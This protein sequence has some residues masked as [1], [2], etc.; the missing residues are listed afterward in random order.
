MLVSLHC[1]GSLAPPAVPHSPHSC[2]P[3]PVSLPLQVF[4]EQKVMDVAGADATLVVQ[5][6]VEGTRA[7]VEAS[8]AP[9]EPVHASNGAA[10]EAA[11][12]PVRGRKPVG[13]AGAAAA[14]KKEREA[15]EAKE[16]K[17]KEEP[18]KKPGFDHVVVGVAV[19]EKFPD[20]HLKC[21]LMG[22]C[23]RCWGAASALPAAL[24]LLC[25]RPAC[26]HRGAAAAEAPWLTTCPSCP[27][28]AGLRSSCTLAAWH[29][30][31]PSGRS[32]PRPGPASRRPCR[33]T[34]SPQ[35]L[36][37]LAGRGCVL[38]SDARLLLASC[39]CAAFAPPTHLC[40]APAL[41]PAHRLALV[42]SLPAPWPAGAAAQVP[43]QRYSV[44]AEDGS[45]V[46]VDPY[47]FALALRMP[48]KDCLAHG[49]RCARARVRVSVCGGLL[50]LGRQAPAWGAA[51]A[52]HGPAAPPGA[53]PSHTSPHL[54]QPTPPTWLAQRHG[55]RAEDAGRP[56]A[57][58]AAGQRKLLRAAAPAQVNQAGQAKQP[59]RSPRPCGLRVVARPAHPPPVDVDAPPLSAAVKNTYM[60]VLTTLLSLLSFWT[61]FCGRRNLPHP[62][63]PPSAPCAKRTLSA[64]LELA[65]FRSCSPVPSPM[66]HRAL[67]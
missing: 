25:G 11:P 16:A 10:A 40:L 48:L 13:R 39:N 5:I 1:G 57:V 63:A 62:P 29:T 44:A 12:A 14:A 60:L 54:A 8:Q 34:V 43:F 22:L 2:L 66:L 65:C 23:C 37:A 53:A 41:A 51:A 61:C 26:D 42:R 4:V 24:P 32:R 7:A 3:H 17:E 27:T 35:P 19:A 67:L 30:R 15:R 50:A 21:A 36:R 64:S 18:K 58:L 9:P 28:H 55:V 49:I 47:L 38:G 46:L 45:P 59:L 31:A 6:Y 52:C 33:A 56:V 20:G